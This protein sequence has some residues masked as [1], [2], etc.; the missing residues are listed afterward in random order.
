MGA[1]TNRHASLLTEPLEYVSKY[2][3]KDAADEAGEDEDEE[4]EM[5]SAGSF[6]DDEDEEP[7]GQMEV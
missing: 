7:A 3:N 4:D 6:S 5:S 2:A 1:D